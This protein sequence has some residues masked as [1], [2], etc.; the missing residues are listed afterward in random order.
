MTSEKSQSKTL[1][2]PFQDI[3]KFFIWD[4]HSKGMKKTVHKIKE[5]EFRSK[6][7]G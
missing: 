2:K 7:I 3:R 6:L 5:E 1:K 4:K